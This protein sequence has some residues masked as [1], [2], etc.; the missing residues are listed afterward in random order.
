MTSTLDVLKEVLSGTWE[1]KTLEALCE[2]SLNFTNLKKA[3]GAVHSTQV[4]RTI[5]RLDRLALIDHVFTKS[6]DFYRISAR[7]KRILEILKNIDKDASLE[8]ICKSP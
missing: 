2:G 7:G 5:N 8:A 4:S 1:L 6:G 3:I